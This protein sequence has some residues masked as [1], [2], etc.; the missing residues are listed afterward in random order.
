MADDS[1][2]ESGFLSLERE[3]Q[4]EALEPLIR[5]GSLLDV[6]VEAVEALP[7]NPEAA[8]YQDLWL[9]LAALH[10][11]EQRIE[12]ELL[13]PHARAFL[14]L[15]ERYRSEVAEPDPDEVESPEEIWSALGLEEES[16]DDP[17]RRWPALME[18]IIVQA[19]PRDWQRAF[20]FVQ[21]V[22]RLGS[23]LDKEQ[24]RRLATV[25]GA[26]VLASRQHRRSLE[27]WRE[28]WN[29]TTYHASDLFY[30]DSRLR[31]ALLD[32][33]ID[34]A[35]RLMAVLA[36]AGKK[37]TD[38]V[39]AVARASYD[40][41]FQE[42]DPALGMFVGSAGLLEGSPVLSSELFRLGLSKLVWDLAFEE[43]RENERIFYDEI[44]LIKSREILIDFRKAM[45][46]SDFTQ[47]WGYAEYAFV[48]G[49]EPLD[50][51]DELVR[52]SPSFYEQGTDLLWLWGHLAAVESLLK[53]LPEDFG[54]YVMAHTVRI[55]ARCPKAADVLDPFPD[56]EQ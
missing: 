9:G 18:Q 32:R 53:L 21:A 4:N 31:R 14:T 34:H 20:G 30:H 39:G 51:Y 45:L 40:L 29:R 54:I 47:A 16:L 50:L 23:R 2:L 55:T 24:Q 26:I 35:Y 17:A 44:S 3:R 10:L 6:L 41:D 13:R 1:I 56:E 49:F 36:K 46:R 5:S 52:L 37:T 8:R 28:V 15:M 7:W 25:P 33:N 42:D 48:H 12:P 38:L 27:L 43:K 19:G 11:F 22:R